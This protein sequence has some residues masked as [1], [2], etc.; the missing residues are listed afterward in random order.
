MTKQLDNRVAA[1]WARVSGPEQQSLPSQ[2]V[3]VKEWLESQ[4][5]SVPLERT[6]AV[7]WTSTDILRCPPMQVL[8]G[9]VANHEVDAVGSLH[10]DRFAARPGQVA[11]ILDIFRQSGVELKLKQTPLP[12]GLMGE[13][14]GLVISIGKAL[15]V[16]RA[17]QGAKQG[18][19][20]RPKLY[21]VPVTYRKPY[22]YRWESTPRRLSPGQKLWLL[23]DDDWSVSRFI[24]R[25]AYAGA[26][27]RKIVSQ[28]YGSHIPS[29]VRNAKWCIQSVVGIL[30]NPVYAGRYHALRRENVEPHNRVRNTYGKSSSCTLPFEQ[31]TYLPTVEVINPPL[32]WEEWLTVQRRLENNKLLAQR[33]AT[34]DYLLRGIL[35]CDIHHR[36]MRGWPYHKKWRYVC[37][38]GDGCGHWVPGPATEE[39]AR[40]VVALL[41]NDPE[42]ALQPT[43]TK[44]TEAELKK[45]LQSLELKRTRGL[46]SLV[47]LERRHTDAS[48]EGI[49]RVDDEVYRRLK[50]QYQAQIQWCTE[51]VAELDRQLA[52]LQHQAEVASS[53]EQMRVELSSKLSGFSNAEWRRLFT[54]LGMTMH[55]E[56]SGHVVA[57]CALPYRTAAD[58]AV[59]IVSSSS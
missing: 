16:E 54:D 44:Q 2:V 1:I 40:E 50:L 20:D 10:L 41:L 12:T 7:D 23:P 45:E 33:N 35:V 36:R 51:R 32:T 48:V 5:Y 8:L 57:H 47:E 4:G 27:S 43:S 30:K 22:G 58:K 25:E 49:Y 38:V 39:R 56:D 59:V 26:S 11:Q 6:L 19:H 37:P 28:L 15:S 42:A 46:N 17:D 52:N 9:W 14:M 24:C 18:L 21:N 13:L 55:V 3:E 31:W 34:H 53:L 29:P